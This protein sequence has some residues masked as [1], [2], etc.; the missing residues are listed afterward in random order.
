MSDEEFKRN[1]IECMN[2]L[3]YIASDEYLDSH[4]DQEIQLAYNSALFDFHFAVYCY[5]EHGG[6][7]D[8]I[9]GAVTAGYLRYDTFDNIYPVRV[10]F[11]T[12]IQED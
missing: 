4:S 10:V 2:K 1:V 12:E 7:L 9:N 5:R 6:R 8:I 3:N 11:V